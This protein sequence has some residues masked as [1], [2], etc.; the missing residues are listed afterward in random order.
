MKNDRKLNFLSSNTSLARVVAFVIGIPNADIQFWVEHKSA[1]L[2]LHGALVEVCDSPAAL[3]EGMAI[4]RVGVVLTM[5]VA[6]DCG[7]TGFRSWCSATWFSF[8]FVVS[9][10][11]ADIQIWVEDELVASIIHKWALMEVGDSPAALVEGVAALGVYKVFSVVRAD[12]VTRA[13][14]GG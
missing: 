5:I 11:V 6:A 3:V 2:V 8:A 10:P 13:F 7:A 12:D 14:F 4:S 1:R 9:W